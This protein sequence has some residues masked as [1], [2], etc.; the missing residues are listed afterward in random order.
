MLNQT[1]DLAGACGAALSSIEPF[2][3]PWCGP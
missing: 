2:V 1:I 3:A